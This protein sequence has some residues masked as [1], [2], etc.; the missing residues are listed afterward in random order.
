MAIFQIFGAK[1]PFFLI[2][3][4]FPNFGAKSCMIL[5]KFS[6]S[7]VWTRSAGS[8]SRRVGSLKIRYR[9]K[10]VKIQLDCGRGKKF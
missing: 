1:C 5:E 9:N 8:I 7:P 2:S 10:V 4:Q 6:I 3:K